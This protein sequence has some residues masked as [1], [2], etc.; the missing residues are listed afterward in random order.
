MGAWQLWQR[1]RIWSYATALLNAWNS[2]RERTLEFIDVALDRLA[3][4]NT[5]VAPA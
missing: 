3:R 2:Q 4:S 5:C 1:I